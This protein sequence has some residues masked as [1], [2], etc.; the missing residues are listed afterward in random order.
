MAHVL[1]Q[2]VNRYMNDFTKPQM[3]LLICGTILGLLTEALDL[4]KKISYSDHLNHGNYLFWLG[5]NLSSFSYKN[6]Y[7]LFICKFILAFA[8]KVNVIHHVW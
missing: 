4:R 8:C 7:F 5:Q 3:L 2:E 1:F 6:E